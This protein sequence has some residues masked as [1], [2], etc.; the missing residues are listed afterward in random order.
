MSDRLVQLRLLVPALCG[1]LLLRAAH[2]QLVRGAAYLRLAEQNRLRLVPEQAP[3]GLIVDRRGATLATNRTAFRVAIVPQETAD[4]G[5]ILAR[6]G[7]L[8]RRRPDL[9]E[10]TFLKERSLAFVPAVIVPDVPKETALLIEEDRAGLPGVLVKPEAARHYPH[11]SSAAHLLGHLSQPMAEELPLLKRYGVR[12]KELVG[13]AGLEQLL[14]AALR[15]RSGG[16]MVEVNHRGRQVRLLGRRSPDAGA[17]VTLTIDAPLQSLVE[18]LLG[19]QPGACVVLDPRTGAVLAMAS[20]P[21]F[22][23]GVFVGP[24][25]Q[26]AAQ[27]LDDPRSPLMNRAA[28][29]VY[30]PGS[31]VKL[32]TAVAALEHRLITLQTTVTCTGSITIGDRTF[33]CWNRDGHGPMTLTDAIMQSCNVYFMSIGLRLGADRLREALEH[34]GVAQKSGWPLE[35]QAGHLP[36]RRLTQGEVALLAIGQGEIL[37]TALRAALVAAAFAN[38]GWVVQPWVVQAVAGRPVAASRARR[39]LPWSNE[40]LAAVRGGMREVVR[41]PLGTGHRAFNPS[42]ALAGKTGTAQT[43]VPDRTHGWFIGFCPVDEPRV[44]MAIV[45]EYGGSGGD[46]PAEVARAVCEYVSVSDA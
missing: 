11:G 43:H 34:A 32:I 46:L 10:R 23:P 2:L 33:H 40:S 16:L 31:I 3:R 38:G 6:L 39:R 45:T 30:Q 27:L 4:V 25:P 35:E 22:D 19:A 17:R 1:V 7:M 42:V 14:D 37:M 21:S 9:L 44:A 15:G 26:A 41:N 8:L 24:E 29:G 5:A 20:L 12:P 13:R 36:R 28:V 18:Q